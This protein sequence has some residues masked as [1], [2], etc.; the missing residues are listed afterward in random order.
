MCREFPLSFPIENLVLSTVVVESWKWKPLWSY[1][2]TATAVFGQTL[3]IT[4][5]KVS[6][7]VP[8]LLL[9]YCPFDIR[10]NL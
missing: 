9:G 2:H 5:F 1:I 6:K 10:W 7:V 4:A 3:A 8:L